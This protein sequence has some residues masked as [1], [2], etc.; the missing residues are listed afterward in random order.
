VLS[1]RGKAAN[2]SV[3]AMNSESQGR[4]TSVLRRHPVLVL[5]R[6]DAEVASWPLA[7]WARPDLALV[8]ELARLQLEA[9][10]VGCSI[11][12]RD[13][14]TELVEL[15]DLVGLSD[16]VPVVAPAGLRIEAGGEAEGREKVGV[17]EVVDPGDP[18]A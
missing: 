18:V 13:A 16:V 7:R 5:V 6:G 10:R 2:S 17:E 11:R 14:C 8:E 3:A 15:L 1:D 12:L 9:R 4:R